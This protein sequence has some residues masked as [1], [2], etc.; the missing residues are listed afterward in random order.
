MGNIFL[1]S[2]QTSMIDCD[3]GSDGGHDIITIATL[4]NAIETLEY[5][6]EENRDKP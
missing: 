3:H 2:F 1:I 4:N 5:T 6:T